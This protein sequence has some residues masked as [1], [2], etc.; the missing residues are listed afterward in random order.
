MTV[1]QSN[2][3]THFAPDNSQVG[4]QLIVSV[5]SRGGGQGWGGGPTWGS[6]PF[7]NAETKMLSAITQSHTQAHSRTQMRARPHTFQSQSEVKVN[8]AYFMAEFQDLQ[9]G[10]FLSDVHYITPHYPP[11]HIDE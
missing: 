1:K 6:F 8:V 2:K 5:A 11:T 4:W 10:G 9:N 7:P 3:A